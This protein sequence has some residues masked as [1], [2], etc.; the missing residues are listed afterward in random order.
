[1]VPLIRCDMDKKRWPSSS[2]EMKNSLI[3]AFRIDTLDQNADDFLHET[4]TVF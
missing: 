4:D 2:E 1:M 3:N